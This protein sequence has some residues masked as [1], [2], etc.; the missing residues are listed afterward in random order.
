[1]YCRK[2]GYKIADDSNFC[3]ACGAEVV[4]TSEQSSAFQQPKPT[5]PVRPPKPKKEH[6]TLFGW[7]AELWYA[8]LYVVTAL[9]F[10]I[11]YLI[12]PALLGIVAVLGIMGGL[13]L[14]FSWIGYLNNTRYHIRGS[15][16]PI[17]PSNFM[18]NVWIN[19]YLVIVVAFCFFYMMG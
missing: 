9:V 4:T 18:E 13:G 10:W 17:E 5:K 14:A 16:Q 1:M 6:D 15:T 11:L 2:C 3:F 8:L 12:S 19:V 7:P